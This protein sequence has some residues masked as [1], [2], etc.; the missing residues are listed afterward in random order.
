MLFLFLLL[1]L[2]KIMNQQNVRLFRHTILWP[3]QLETDSLDKDNC[4][5]EILE[6]GAA[7]MHWRRVADNFT[8]NAKTFQERHYKEFVTFLPY[9]QRFLYGE[10]RSTRRTGDT[11]PCPPAMHV[12]RRTDVTAMRITTEANSKPLIIDVEHVELFFFQD[13][14]VVLLK[15]EMYAENLPFPLVMDL[16]HRFGRAY[17]AGWHADGQ[18][19]HNLFQLEILGNN[20]QVL[21]VSDSKFKEK[22]LDFVCLH[23]A[24]GIASHW[25]FLLRPLLLDH[26]DEEGKLRYSQ[27]EYHR[28][29][30]LAYLA[31]ED[32][33][34]ISRDDFIHLGLISHLRP[35]DKLPI[36]DPS[37]L[38]F[39]SRYCDDRYWCDTVE[40]PNTRV[41]CSGHTMIMIGEARSSHFTDGEK[42]L[43]AQF[44]HQ[45]FLL[46]LITHFHRAALLVFSDRL[47]DAINRLDNNNADSIRKFKQ[48]IRILFGIFLR[49]T[50][51]YWFHEISE[52]GQVQSLFRRNSSHLGNDDLYAEV[53]E[54]IKDMSQYLDSDSQR[55][56]SNT[57][58]RLT[59]VTTFGMIATVTTGF[60]G[61]NLIAEAEAPIVSRIIFFLVIF[62]ISTTLTLFAVIKSKRLSD[63]LEALSNEHL[64]KKEKLKA[65]FQVLW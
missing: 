52:R 50:H 40:G 41:L 27:I 64:S 1:S 16:L 5:W 20:S 14:D 23:R 60:L 26:S 24:S 6:K 56:Q 49:F 10:S 15:V 42:G 55:R 17:P 47:V 4:P 45:Y 57:V 38:E 61:I 35:K 59:V 37:V 12:F 48:R 32:P 34:A 54:H 13:I 21:A 51:R 33:R 3:L 62:L 2:T 58:V 65:L 31:M 8:F 39:E 29:P 7:T 46:F 25:E 28:M 18:G 53:N 19:L 9:V 30:M 22:Y 43:L 44:R 11:S 36:H 63:F